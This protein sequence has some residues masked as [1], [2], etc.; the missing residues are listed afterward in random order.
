MLRSHYEKLKKNK[1]YK[2]RLHLCHT[3]GHIVMP[4]LAVWFG[5]T[6]WVTGYAHILQISQKINIIIQIVFTVIWFGTIFICTKYW[7]K[8]SFNTN[9]LSNVISK[10]TDLSVKF[11]FLNKFVFKESDE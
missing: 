8:I 4:S 9:N 5:I 2:R 11:G 3:V 7:D 10:D 6:Y 1:S